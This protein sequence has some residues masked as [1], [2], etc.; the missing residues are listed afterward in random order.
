MSSLEECLFRSFTQFL[1]G[2]FGLLILSFRNC[3]C[4][5]EINALLVTL[6][7]NIVS[8]SVGLTFC[9]I[10]GILCCAKSFKFN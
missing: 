6:F 5:L 9:F 7:E 3:L 8:H 1:N 4:I 2:L 10:Y